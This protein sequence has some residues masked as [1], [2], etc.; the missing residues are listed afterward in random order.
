MILN[1]VYFEDVRKEIKAYRIY[2]RKSPT[3]YLLG[4]TD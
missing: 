4:I 1:I 2:I 3:G